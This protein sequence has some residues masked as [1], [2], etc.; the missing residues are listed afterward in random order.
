MTAEAADIPSAWQ[1]SGL[2]DP[3]PPAAIANAA[4]GCA[5]ALAALAGQTLPMRGAALLGQRRALGGPDSSRCQLLATGQGQLLLNLARADDY[6]LLPAWLEADIDD[7]DTRALQA[8]LLERS[9]RH[10]CARGRE[11]GLALAVVRAPWQCTTRAIVASRHAPAAARPKRPPRLLDLSTLWAGPLAAQ[12]LRQAAGA[13]VIKLDSHSR[14]DGARLGAPA[15]Y[16]ALND[17][18]QE[19]QL[20]DLRNASGLKHLRAAIADADIVIESARPRG[21]QQLGIIAQDC[22]AE[23]SGLTWV[24]ITGYGRSA[25]TAQHIAYGDDAGV[26]AGLGWLQCR[27]WGGSAVVGDAIA[28]PLTGLHAAVAALAGYQAGGG[29]LWQLQLSGVV[30]QV[31]GFGAPASHRAWRARAQGWRQVIQ[32][33]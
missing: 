16:A 15:F 20:D 13:E 14:P 4:D 1:A 30:R 24:S 10:W 31:I 3:C 6:A 18:K 19:L 25:D 5:A 11:L 27:A 17:G 22:I 26:A 23:H 21:L 8:R 2:P 9:A 33:G 7:C 32:K 12:C 28:D 29:Q